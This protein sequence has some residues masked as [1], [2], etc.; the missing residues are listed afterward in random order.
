MA[1]YPH[2]GGRAA[3]PGG[4]RGVSPEHSTLSHSHRGHQVPTQDIPMGN[5]E[6]PAEGQP[7][8]VGD[9]GGS[10][11]PQVRL[12]PSVLVFLQGLGRVTMSWNWTVVLDAR[13]VTTQKPPDHALWKEPVAHQGPWVPSPAL[14]ATSQPHC[15]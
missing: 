10:S 8:P 1:L 6:R 7:A 4:D 9:S 2:Q 3:G 11:C 15:E 12:L 13:S 14:Q 5:P